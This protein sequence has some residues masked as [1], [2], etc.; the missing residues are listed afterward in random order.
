MCGIT[1][2]IGYFNGYKYVLHGLIMLLSRGYDGAGI[3][4]IDPNKN[5]VLVIRFS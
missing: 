5:F 1:G 3:C 2:F 4:G